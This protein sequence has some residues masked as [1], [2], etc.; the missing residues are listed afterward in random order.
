MPGGSTQRTK[1]LSSSRS[2]E[3]VCTVCPS[4]TKRTGKA[5]ALRMPILCHSAAMDWMIYGASGYT[6]EL[7][8]E[9]A[10][11]KGLSPVLAGRSE[12]KVR[13]L[14]EKLGFRWR[15]FSLHKPRLESKQPALH[16]PRTFSQP[17]RQTGG[18]RLPPES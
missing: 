8:A 16:C 7:I 5:I 17:S 12:A 2:R 15:G 13:P 18:A 3:V 4:A 6:G 11:T 1:T 9:L 14:A 10:R